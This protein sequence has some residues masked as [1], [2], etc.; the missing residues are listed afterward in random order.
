MPIVSIDEINLLHN[1]I[2]Q[3]VGDPKRIQILYALSDHPMNVTA[4]AEALDTPQPTISRH[5]SLLR[6]R[7]LVNTERDG[8]TVTYSVAATGL[9]DILDAMRHLLREVMEKQATKL[10]D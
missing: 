6:Q 3:A 5:L 2:C 9:I 1:T 10:E 7:G 4:L 8:V